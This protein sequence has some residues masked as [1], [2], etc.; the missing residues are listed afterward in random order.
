MCLEEAAAPV[1]DGA[2]TA[3]QAPQLWASMSIHLPIQHAAWLG[4]PKYVTVPSVHQ[5]Q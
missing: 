5:D 4:K 1:G 2:F 3:L